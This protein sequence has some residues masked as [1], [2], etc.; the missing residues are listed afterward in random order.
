MEVYFFQ[1]LLYFD[2]V[3]EVEVSTMVMG[4]FN[5]WKCPER[6]DDRFYALD[7]TKEVNIIAIIKFQKQLDC[8]RNC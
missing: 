8:S 1:V 7:N 6:C 4:S 2:I 5:S 3:I